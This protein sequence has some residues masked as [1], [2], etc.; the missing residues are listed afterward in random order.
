MVMFT[1][2]GC[3]TPRQP[4]TLNA[5]AFNKPISAIYV[6]PIIADQSL[7]QKLMDTDFESMTETIESLLEQY[8]YHPVSVD[9]WGTND[10]ISDQS[11]VNMG[12]TELCRLAPTK[13][14][15][16]LVT[17]INVVPSNSAIVSSYRLYCTIMAIDRE[18][19]AVIWKDTRGASAPIWISLIDKTPAEREMLRKVFSS[20]PT[21]RQ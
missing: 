7:E 1:M 12:V 18:K 8:G 16:F 5:D 13:S 15:V 20:I 19:E 10:T 17:T 11:L 2:T 3:I 6:M 9:S 14:K 21:N 4:I